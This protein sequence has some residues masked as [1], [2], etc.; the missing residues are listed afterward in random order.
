M[1]VTNSGVWPPSRLQAPSIDTMRRR[2]GPIVAAGLI[3][4]ACSSGGDGSQPPDTT[5]ASAE[6]AEQPST[7]EG[8][9]A[10]PTTAVVDDTAP[11]EA[12]P[13]KPELP[14]LLDDSNEKIANDDSVRTGTLDNGLRYYVRQNDNPGGKASLRLAIKAGSVDE[15]GPSSGLAHFVEHMLFNGT[16]QFPENE[17]IDVLRSFGAAFGADV[18]AYTDFDET[19]YELTVPND[20]QPLQAGLTVLEQW[21]SHA[22]FDPDQVVAERGVVLD[23]WRLSTQSVRG[24]LFDV[25]E[26]MYLADTAYDGRSPI[27]TDESISAMTDTELREFYDAWYRPDNASVIVVG[28]I[29]VD[30]VVADI[31]RLFGPAVARSAEARTAPNVEFPVDT[32]PDFGLHAD[33]DQQT[34]DVEVTLPLPSFV[35]NGTAAWRLQMIDLII[36]DALVRRLDQDVAAGEASFDLIVPGTN[37]LVHSL[38][39]PAL[40]AVTDAARAGET[41]QALLDE[42]ER[43]NRFGFTESEVEVAQSTLRGSY[44]SFYAGRESAQDADYADTYVDH[45]LNDTAYPTIAHEYEISIGMLEAITAEAVDLRF[46]ARWANSAAHVIISTPDANADQMPTESEVLTMIAGTPERDLNPREGQRDLPAELMA[47]PQQV[48]VDSVDD[49]FAGSDPFFDPLDLVFP[50]GVRVILNSNTIVEGQVYFRAASPGGSSLVADEDVVDA[51]YAADVV[52]RGGIADFNQSELTQILAGSTADVSAFITPHVDYFAGSA[53]TADLEDLMQLVHLYMTQPRFDPVALAQL[54]SQVGPAVADP[55]SRPDLAGDD[56]YLDLR[57]PGELRY[58]TLPTPEQFDTLDLEG[59]ERVWNAR[60][61]NAADWVFV[62]SGDLDF[63]ELVDLSGLYLGTLPATQPEQWV[64]VE[65]PPPAGVASATIEA[66]TGDTASLTIEFTSPVATVDSALRVHADVATEVMSARLTDVIRERNGESY[67][68]YAVSYVSADP[69]PA[70]VTYVSVTGSP[71]R[72]GAVA[73]LVIAELADLA[74]SGPT[75][76][77]FFNAHAQVE[78]AYNFVNNGEFLTE[79]IED[80]IFPALDVDAYLF[81]YDALTPVTA[82]SVRSFI[83]SHVPADRYIKVTVLPR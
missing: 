74:R 42:Y 29:D 75:E 61:G 54:K 53:A 57:Y 34:V 14:G 9:A 67:S 45:F 23:E 24:R 7:G 80:A 27:G 10:A 3:L 81:E 2:L 32:D 73:D 8:A 20:D 70:I 44:E 21:L 22:T 83:S 47:R 43:A 68:P 1:N 31:E 33:P 5:S 26:R 65:D 76:Q 66:G 78:E 40:Y 48:S 55:A 13:D 60:F 63:S 4:A 79:L 41:L 72:I 58:A 18:N 19:V 82:G 77:E 12:P 69:D 25:A 51:L 71:D 30:D 56:A 37:S 46:R 17:L 52:T 11:T 50:N 62:F 49:R 64:D 6:P 28:E 59:V 36:N 16:E 35:G 38:D 15:F 39:A